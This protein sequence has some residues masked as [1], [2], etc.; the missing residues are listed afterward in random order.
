MRDHIISYWALGDLVK[1]SQQL[2]GNKGWH[3][4]R[5]GGS[6]SR[7]ER[8][9]GNQKHCPL[10]AHFCPRSPMHVSPNRLSGLHF[11]SFSTWS[12]RTQEAM[13][14]EGSVL[15]SNIGVRHGFWQFIHSQ[16]QKQV[17]TGITFWKAVFFCP[18]EF[19][20]GCTYMHKLPFCLKASIYKCE[21][22]KY[23]QCSTISHSALTFSIPLLYLM[24]RLWEWWRI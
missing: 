21:W 11:P 14:K 16:N 18:W 10:T 12:E 15:T 2:D 1:F 7:E 17:G 5:G 6:V 9:S 8:G 24:F 13:T 20:T 4:P 19:K 22:G 23:P 3:V